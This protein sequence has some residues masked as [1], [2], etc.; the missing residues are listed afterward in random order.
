MRF[1]GFS[2]QATVVMILP[3]LYIT[4]KHISNFT[5]DK[6]NPVVISKMLFP[7]VATVAL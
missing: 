2:G 1:D 6:S 4:T 3:R 7:A 5:E